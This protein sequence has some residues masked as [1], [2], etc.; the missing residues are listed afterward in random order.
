[1]PIQQFLYKF[2][3]LNV[4]LLFRFHFVLA[5]VVALVEETRNKERELKAQWK[6]DRERK[7]DESKQHQHQQQQRQQFEIFACLY[8]V[9][10]QCIHKNCAFFPFTLHIFFVDFTI[11]SVNAWVGVCAACSSTLYFFFIH[12]ASSSTSCSI[13]YVFC[14]LFFVFLEN[15]MKK[16]PTTTTTTLEHNRMK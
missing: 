5:F 9:R 12:S 1:M 3:F 11:A 14:A 13:L 16:F 6:L 4:G 10:A 7:D 8:F 15:I 2:F